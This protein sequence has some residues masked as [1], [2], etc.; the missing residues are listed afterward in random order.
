[1]K[2]TVSVVIPCYGQ[3][4]FLGEAVESVLSQSHSALEIIVIDDGSPDDVA[5]VVD[6][7]PGVRCISQRNQ[8][9]SLARN[10]GFD[11]SRGE[12]IV[13]LDAD[14]RL[15]PNAL[16]VGVAAL[17]DSPPVAMVWGF[18]RPID[19]EGAILGA[20]SNPW[21]GAVSGYEDLLRRNIVG[22]PLGVMF[23]R[24]AIERCGGFFPGSLTAEDYE[25]YLRVARQYHIACH[26]QL[27]AEYR[28][29]D[30][31][32]S[33][34]LSAMLQGVLWALAEQ[35]PF[36]AT[37]PRLRKALREG[38]RD[39]WRRYE[40]RRRREAVGEFLREGRWVRGTI[41]GLG[42]LVRYPSLFASA[43]AQKLH[44]HLGAGSD[45]G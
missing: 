36:V 35:E 17:T 3:A 14:D 16:E 7:F 31:N 1:M 20:I 30:A 10:A 23:R 38:R 19:R 12:F 34:D 4:H 25:L 11:A 9:L 44:T 45:R 41:E 13:F 8:G 43:V 29:H 22:P 33:S 40:G 42:F 24:R 6:R 28:H 37:D 27:I 26:G 32:M 5:S 2:S 21:D 15:L 39:A 18:N